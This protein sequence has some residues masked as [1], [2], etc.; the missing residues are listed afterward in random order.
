MSLDSAIE[1][2]QDYNDSK[3]DEDRAY[4]QE[5]RIVRYANQNITEC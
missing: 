4:I 5:S 1:N 2:N 3:A